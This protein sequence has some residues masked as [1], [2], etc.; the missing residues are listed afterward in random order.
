[1][2]N[3]KN[4]FNDVIETLSFTVKG[5]GVESE[6][7]AKIEIKK[8]GIYLHF[9]R[10]GLFDRNAKNQDEL[11]V[12]YTTNID[13]NTTITPE[14]QRL[15]KFNNNLIESCL[16]KIDNTR[17]AKPVDKFINYQEKE[18]SLD[19]VTVY[20]KEG[21]S[22]LKN[23]YFHPTNLSTGYIYLMNDDDPNDYCELHV[24][25]FGKLNYVEWKFKRNIGK[26]AK[27]LDVRAPSVTS[28]KSKRIHPPGKKLWVAYS[29]TQ[30]SREYHADLNSDREKR[31]KRMKLFD[32]VAIKKGGQKDKASTDKHLG[33]EEDYRIKP[34]SYREVEAMYSVKNKSEA[35]AFQ[36]T[37]HE[38]HADEKREDLKGTNDTFE[39][40]FFIIDDPIGIAEDVGGLLDEAHDKHRATVES[41][42]TGEDEKDI[43]ERLQ[44]KQE[45]KSEFINSGYGQQINALFCNALTLYKLVNC[46]EKIKDEYEKYLDYKKINTILAFSYREK[47]RERIMYFRQDF[48]RI[49]KSDYYKIYFN[50]GLGGNDQDTFEVRSIIA[51][52]MSLLIEH[53]Q[54]KDRFIDVIEKYKGNNDKDVDSFIESSVNSNDTIRKLLTKEFNIDDFKLSYIAFKNGFT[55]SA[56]IVKSM[57]DGFAAY[58]KHAVR[59]KDFRIVDESVKA[60]KSKSGWNIKIKTKSANS[61]LGK[62]NF[63][64]HVKSIKETPNISFDGKGKTIIIKTSERIAKQAALNK[65]I[66]I[67]GIGLGTKTSRVLQN[68]LENLNFRKFI[69]GMELVI[70]LI[71]VNSYAEKDSNKNLVSLAGAGADLTSAVLAYQEAS[72][73]L[74]NA[75]TRSLRYIGKMG[76]VAGL[77][78]SGISV[79]MCVRDSIDSYQLRDMDASITWGFTAVVGGVLLAD[80]IV[81]C[82]AWWAAGT[83]VGFLTFGWGLV[84]LVLFVG[85][86]MLAMYLTDKALERFLKNNILSNDNPFNSTETM[87]YKYVQA[88]YNNSDTLVDSEVAR[89]RDFVV[90]SDDLYDLLISYRVDFQYLEMVDYK[91]NENE[92]ESMM[93]YIRSVNQIGAGMKSITYKKIVI[94]IILQKFIHNV[95]EFNYALV[96]FPKGLKNKEPDNAAIFLNNTAVRLIEYK[97]LDGLQIEFSINSNLRKI[98]TRGSEFLLFS[99]VCVNK[100]AN[101]YWPSQRGKSR[102]HGY[103]FNAT[104]DI[105]GMG[106]A[107]TAKFLAEISNTV[108]NDYLGANIRIGTL[109]EI[110]NWK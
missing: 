27:E 4:A 86:T 6:E 106:R 93:D 99:Q 10:L 105:G 76:R 81:A 47:Q 16:V 88:L 87:P 9:L 108:M 31:K 83:A 34:I 21:L 13:E 57:K 101:E 33:G 67:P 29:A 70:T 61:H 60:F 50:D 2:T 23:F 14:Q 107:G 79:A 18:I 84:F 92:K 59:V 53:P 102:Y 77:F 54:H 63:G 1:M 52:H 49:L 91:E 74:E 8:K 41:I 100:E 103:K 30:W 38:I 90:A 68:L 19:K 98:M 56:M 24:D 25:D 66:I 55:L 48:L 35:Y 45:G 104:N 97:K 73:Q 17:V 82:A 95:S 28:I 12:N 20:T 75:T 42:Q 65:S 40:L 69:A 3:Q 89:W 44:N 5:A 32:C 15:I 36:K 26:D 37:L 85:L 94:T 51:S 62:L 109:K 110:K 7:E 11:D 96:L 39:D 72:M 58:T 71:K 80:G 78:G 64:L 43:F 46:D 22:G